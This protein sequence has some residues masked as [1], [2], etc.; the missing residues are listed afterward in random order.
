M[1]KVKVVL[2]G[3]SEGGKTTLANFLADATENSIS[4]QYRPT[5]G[6]RILEFES[7][8][9]NVNNRFARAEVELWDASGNPAHENCW[10]AVKKDAHGVV[11]VFDP[12]VEE[13]ARALEPFYAYFVEKGGLSETQCVVFASCRADGKIARGAKLGS[14]FNRIP[15]LQIN[16]AE[17]A[18]R[19]RN[20]F[21]TF[22][23]SLLNNLSE[24]S[25]QEEMSI[26]NMRN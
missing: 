23:V 10:P 5:R 16:I 21:N 1:F 3:P 15:Q 17:E 13:Q 19:V 4:E 8:N 18:N 24:K 11:F 9:L 14:Q 2:A 25:E 20:D 12:S 22:L 7:N 6:L 26:M